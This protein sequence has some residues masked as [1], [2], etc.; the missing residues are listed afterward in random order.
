MKINR[1]KV[2]LSFFSNIYIKFTLL[3]SGSFHKKPDMML[4]QPVFMV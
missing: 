4:M 2:F 3:T 1:K